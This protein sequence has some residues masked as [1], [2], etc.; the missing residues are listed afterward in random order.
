M[1]G[2]TNS[3]FYPDV[4]LV[5]AAR[6]LQ[7]QSNARRANSQ[8]RRKQQ[9]VRELTL[10]SLRIQ[11][12]RVLSMAKDA[13]YRPSCEKLVAFTTPSCPYM[14]IHHQDKTKHMFSFVM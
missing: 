3:C 2:C 1:Q 6:V 14:K 9:V 11:T 5:W 7:E 13:M 8:A 10:Q 12:M 4:G